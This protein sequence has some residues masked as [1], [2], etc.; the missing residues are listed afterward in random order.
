MFSS[1]ASPIIFLGLVPAKEF[2]PSSLPKPLHTMIRKNYLLWGTGLSFASLFYAIHRLLC[3]KLALKGTIHNPLFTTLW[4]YDH[5]V[6][7]IKGIKSECFWKA[8]SCLLDTV[9]PALKALRY[10]DSN[11]L[12]MDNVFCIFLS[13]QVDEA[14]LNSQKLLDD[15]HSLDQ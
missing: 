8:S 3:Q 11:V 12:E 1:T 9:F 6:A 4:K 5:V 2:I 7:A 14:L 15:E 10:C 13:R